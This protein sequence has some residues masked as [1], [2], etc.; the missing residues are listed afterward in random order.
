M[1]AEGTCSGG[2]WGQNYGQWCSPLWHPVYG[3]VC[4]YCGVLMSHC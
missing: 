3:W 1:S 2:E 4:G